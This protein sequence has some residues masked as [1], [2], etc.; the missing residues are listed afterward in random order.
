[1]C[2]LYTIRA[3]LDSDFDLR[4]DMQPVMFSG[5]YSDIRS[6]WAATLHSAMHLCWY[7]MVTSFDVFDICCDMLWQVRA[8]IYLVTSRACSDNHCI[9]TNIYKHVCW[10]V[11]IFD[12][13]TTNSTCLTH[14]F[15]NGLKYLLTPC[16]I[17]MLLNVVT[18]HHL[19]TQTPAFLMIRFWRIHYDTLTYTDASWHEL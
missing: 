19:L 13:F 6:G 14:L 1:M 17:V 5:L 16:D 10:Y 8:Y 7:C 4:S 9:D 18:H 15:P 11:L 3:C 2:T 12:T